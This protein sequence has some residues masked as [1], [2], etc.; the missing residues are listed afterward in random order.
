MPL[1][2]LKQR[3]DLP[4]SKV[5]LTIQLSL[6]E[7]FPVCSFDIGFFLFLWPQDALDTASW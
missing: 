5:F 3:R 1:S 7:K 6:V 4:V 2:F